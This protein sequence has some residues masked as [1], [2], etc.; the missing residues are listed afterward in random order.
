[1]RD[2]DGVATETAKIKKVKDWFEKAK[3]QL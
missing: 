1:M 2:A 3:T